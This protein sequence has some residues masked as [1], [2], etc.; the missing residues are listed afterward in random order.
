MFICLYV[1]HLFHVTIFESHLKTMFSD[2]KY[3]EQTNSDFFFFKVVQ[4]QLHF[5]CL[6]ENKRHIVTKRVL[7]FNFYILTRLEFF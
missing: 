6:S 7:S 3:T 2:S 4:K 5:M 1:I